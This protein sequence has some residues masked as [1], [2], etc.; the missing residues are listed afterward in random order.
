LL[1]VSLSAAPY[2]FL[3]THPGHSEQFRFDNMTTGVYWKQLLSSFD[4]Q[5]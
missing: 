2:N 1:S 4:I 5:P 3:R